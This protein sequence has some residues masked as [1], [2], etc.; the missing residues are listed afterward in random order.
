MNAH[1]SAR[2]DAGTGVCVRGLDFALRD[3]AQVMTAPAGCS[4]SKGN[5][6]P[7]VDAYGVDDL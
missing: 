4:P 2:G 1:L 5:S 7:T 6:R 3:G